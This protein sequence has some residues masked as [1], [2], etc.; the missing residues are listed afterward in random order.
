M[1]FN[2]YLLFELKQNIEAKRYL[3]RSFYTDKPKEK[4]LLG[5]EDQTVY[6]KDLERCYFFKFSF[7]GKTYFAQF[8]LRKKVLCFR[9]ECTRLKNRFSHWRKLCE[10]SQRENLILCECGWNYSSLGKILVLSLFLKI[11]LR[12]VVVRREKF[13]LLRVSDLSESRWDKDVWCL[14]P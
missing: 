12:S 11:W 9:E 13:I 5:L 14:C 2:D 7:L 1:C 10:L 3:E 6:A 8:Y 4:F